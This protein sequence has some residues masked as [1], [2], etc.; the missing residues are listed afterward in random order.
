M[1]EEGQWYCELNR[2]KIGEESQGRAAPQELKGPDDTTEALVKALTDFKADLFITSGH[3]TERDWQ[4]GYRYHNGQFRCRDGLL[5]GVDTQRREWPI[6]SPNPRVFLPVGNCLMGHI[7]RPDC[8]ALAWMG[9]AGVR[10]MAGYTQPTWYGYMGWGLLDYFVEQPGRYTLTEAFFANQAALIHRLQTNFPGAEG[11]TLDPN[12]RSEAPIQA[13]ARAREAGLTANDARGLLFDRDT[14]AFYG[15]PA[16]QARLAD[17]PRA[18]EQS[19]SRKANRYVFE[20]LP[21]RGTNT[22]EPINRNGSQRGGRPL[23]QFFPERLGDIRIVAGAELEPL[24]TDNFILVPNPDRCDPSRQYRVE[25][26]AQ[27]LR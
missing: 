2:G 22:F 25:F 13:G 14:V 23:V 19:L 3:A 11:S 9:S 24:I 26:T 15:D 5:Y 27:T 8:M 1:C 6:Q 18:W 10:Q 16:W 21:R 17:G 4:I 7:D 12:G 20:I